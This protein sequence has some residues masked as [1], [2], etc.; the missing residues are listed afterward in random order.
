M[1]LEFEFAV[2]MTKQWWKEYL[3]AREDVGG[4]KFYDGD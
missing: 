1:Q 2:A 4:E 3:D